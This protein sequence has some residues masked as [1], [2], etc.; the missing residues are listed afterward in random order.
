MGVGWGGVCV[1]GG[2]GDSPMQ[3]LWH[4]FVSGILVVKANR[5]K[6]QK[7]I[8]TIFEN[9]EKAES[10]GFALNFKQNLYSLVTK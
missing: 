5:L 7:K 6:K 1:C 3:H 10:S 4:P 2:G 9:Q 8:Q